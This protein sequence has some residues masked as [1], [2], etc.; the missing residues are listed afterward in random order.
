MQVD[1]ILYNYPEIVFARTTPHQKMLVVEGCQ[2]QGI[3]VG[4][5]GDGIN[6]TPALKKADIGIAMGQTGSDASKQAADVVLLDDNFASIVSG[7]EEGRVVFDNLKKCIAYTLSSNV[8]QMAA[9]ILFIIV[10][11]P[12]PLGTLTI[13]VIDLG[14]DVFPAVSLLF[15]EPEG[16][17]MKRMPRDPKHDP[18]VGRKM[19]SVVFGQTGFIMIVGAFYTYFVI[20]AESGFWPQRLLGLRDEW[21]VRGLN[22]IEDAYGQEWAFAQRMV[23]EY[24][25]QSAF[26]FAIVMMQ[27]S[28]LIICKTRLS[29]IV[30]QRMM[31]PVLTWALMFETLLCAFFL[32]CPGM[33]KGLRMYPIRWT[34]WFA[35]LPFTVLIFAYDEIRKMY[36][37]SHPD[38]FLRHET[39]Y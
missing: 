33:D 22:D 7:I 1:D 35:P 39:Y 3:T 9:F 23:L 28:N 16:D 4:I 11:I 12:L 15:E 24:T 20:M 25:C 36:I 31:N 2:R 27:W 17:I 13:L 6:D 26:F 34:W 8:P 32:Y 5:T 18:L 10:D 37:R 38:S 14:T 30:Q 21:S 19:L 29:S